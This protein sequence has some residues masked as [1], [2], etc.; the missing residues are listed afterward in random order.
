MNLERGRAVNPVVVEVTRGGRV[1]SEHRGAGAVVDADG[2]VV[3]AFGVVGRPVFPRSAVKAIQALPLI[4]SGAADRFGL[5]DEELALACASHSGEPA[6]VAGA[7]SIL[8]KAGRD[9]TALACGV[10][11]PSNAEAAR[12]L[13]RSGAEPSAL[14]N[15]CSGKHAGFVCVACA[16]GLPAEGYETAEHGVQRAVKAALEDV[17]GEPLDDSRRGLD[18]CSIPT[19]AI[20]L[21]GLARGFAKMATGRGLGPARAAA[22]QRLF[23]AVAAHPFHVAGTGRFD[24][25]AMTALGGRV[26]TKTG[27][28][29]V[30]CAALPELGLGLAVKADDGAG[31]A[32][33]VMIAALI[34]RFAE[35]PEA[36]ARLM[37]PRLTNWR[38]SPVGEIRAAGAL[39]G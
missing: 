18:G 29:G 37:R 1:E 10:H 13:A 12:A 38:G 25:L 19:Y 39:A 35:T 34:A 22:A 26:F 16:L 21:Q 28:E 33:E 14:H 17:C 5:S 15:N 27:A 20:S 31:R 36:F 6:H 11:W 3:F 7:A 23:A 4:E 8:A 24:T 32:A 9:E 2:G 30:F